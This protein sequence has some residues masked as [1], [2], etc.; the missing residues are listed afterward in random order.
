MDELIKTLS[1]SQCC[2][3]TIIGLYGFDKALRATKTVSQCQSNY[4][5]GIY[6]IPNA[7]IK[8]SRFIN[9]IVFMRLA[10]G[11]FR[12]FSNCVIGKLRR[13]SAK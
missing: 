9:A 10:Q 8:M 5:F 4:A 6:F 2:M 1:N 7:L 12:G 13:S 11:L 3:L